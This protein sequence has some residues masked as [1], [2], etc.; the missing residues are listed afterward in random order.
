MGVNINYLYLTL[1]LFYIYCSKTKSPTP[2]IEPGP[3]GW[4]PYILTTG[5]Y[6][7]MEMF[8]IA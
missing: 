2:G 4:E 3:Y 6:R 8:E 7:T 5:P 1:E